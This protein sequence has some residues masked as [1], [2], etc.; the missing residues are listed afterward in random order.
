M[1]ESEAEAGGSEVELP[2]LASPR[3][4]VHLVENPNALEELYAELKRRSGPIAIDAERASG[5]KYSQRAYLVQLRCTNSEIFLLDPVAFQFPKEALSNVS[6]VL[7]DREWILHAATQDLPCL[8]ELGLTPGSIYD[9]ELG[10]RLAGES[11]VGLGAL[12]ENLLGFRLE[13]QHSAADW[14]TRPLPQ[15]WLN[16]A[17]LD[18]DVLH[19]LK[20]AVSDLLATQGKTEWANQEFQHLLGFEPKPQRE[21]RWRTLSGLHKISDRQALEIA[22]QL[23]LARELLAQKLDVAPGRLI[24]D[25]SIVHVALSKPKSKPQLASTKEFSGRASRSYLST[26]WDAIEA[27]Q[28]ATALP[29]LRPDKVDLIPNHR[30]WAA[31]FPD[32]DK[33]LRYSKSSIQ[34]VADEANLPV[35]N[36]LTPDYLRKI[37]FEPPAEISKATVSLALSAFGVRAWQLDLVTE[38]IT[39][40]FIQAASE[41]QGPE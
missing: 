28:K 20:D 33:R 29:A 8:A 18:V 23:W 11:R 9:T 7:R 3:V 38:P 14:S 19:E 16:Y 36:L 40:S 10:A 32:A 24:P 17:A 31:K 1:P 30:T 39:K 37:C 21:E 41:Q 13:K 15:S 25:S 22:R 34:T 35:E 4:P 2:L 5:F 27:G 12:T 6:A 26:W